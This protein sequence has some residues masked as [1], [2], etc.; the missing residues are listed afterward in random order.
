MTIQKRIKETE[1]RIEALEKLEKLTFLGVD[2][3]KEY[4]QLQK[5]LAKLKKEDAYF[6]WFGV[7]KEV[8]NQLFDELFKKMAI[9]EEEKV[10][11]K[12]EEGQIIFKNEKLDFDFTVELLNRYGYWCYSIFDK[13][14]VVGIEIK[15]KKKEDF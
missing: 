15:Y 7:N 2:S 13:D 14:K 1:A 10:E 4:R 8:L 9:Y 12:V 6:I 3:I 5:E 11:F